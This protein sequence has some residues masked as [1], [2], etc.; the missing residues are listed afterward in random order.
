MAI[1]D[2]LFNLLFFKSI[3]SNEGRFASLYL[4]INLEIEY[5]FFLTL[6]YVSNEGT[7][8]TRL[9]GIF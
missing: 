4:L 9:I 2:C 5:L 7:A 3:I 8:V 1:H 6:A